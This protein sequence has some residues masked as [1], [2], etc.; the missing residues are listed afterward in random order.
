MRRLSADFHGYATNMNAPTNDVRALFAN[1]P[2]SWK[3]EILIA[4]FAASAAAAVMRGT[5]LGVLTI[6]ATLVFAAFRVDAVLYLFIFFLPFAPLLDTTLPIRD[7]FTFLRIALFGGV[8]LGY[9]F[10]K[11]SLREWLLSARLNWMVIGYGVIALLSVLA[12]SEVNTSSQRALLRLVSYLGFYFVVV[13]WVKSRDQVRMTVQVLL[14][15]T[16]IVALFGIYQATINGYSDLYFRLYPLQE[17]G[18]QPWVG[19]VSSF[20]FHFNSLAGYLN[21][22]LPF[23]FACALLD[24]GNS[25][26][27]LL[28]ATCFAL[29]SITLI[30]TQSR[31]GLIAF[32][33]TVL[34]AIWFFAKNR[35]IRLWSLVTFPI[36]AL[37]AIWVLGTYAERLSGVDEFT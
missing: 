22:I 1:A 25:L 14:L 13:G 8:C 31:G 21:I 36:V 28:G 27:R 7:V 33:G 20:L 2:R 23:A 35:K 19:R 12:F 4:V 6:V 30:L 9:V 26:R 10:S 3:I 37:V 34:L 29:G 15:S 5:V 17:V 16:V 11:N 18:I 32:G 24:Q